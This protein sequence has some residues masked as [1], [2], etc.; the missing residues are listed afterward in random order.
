MILDIILKLRLRTNIRL[1]GWQRITSGTQKQCKEFTR[2]ERKI[3]LEASG[4][5]KQL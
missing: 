1:K 5:Y 4:N 3:V 2:N